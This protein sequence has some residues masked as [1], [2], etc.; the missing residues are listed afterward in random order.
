M[1]VADLLQDVPVWPSTL[2]RLE[3]HSHSFKD[4]EVVVTGAAGSIG[5]A[6]A[7]FLAEAGAKVTGVDHNELE[8]S[9]HVGKDQISWELDDF[10]HFSIPPQTEFIFH[11]AAYKHVDLSARFEKA[12]TENNFNKTVKFVDQARR[13]CPMHTK[14]VVVSTDKAAGNS[15]LG[16]S[17]RDAEQCV[18]AHRGNKYTAIRLVNV[19]R[20][21]GSVLERWDQSLHPW[22]CPAH[23]ER[24]WMT[25]KDAICAILDAA[26]LTRGVYTVQDVP[27]YNMGD[28]AQVYENMTGKRI[29][30]LPELRVGESD[31]EALIGPDEEMVTVLPHIAKIERGNSGKLT[32]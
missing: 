1:I 16:R 12:F 21:R 31:R 2:S 22:V 19:A 5:Y 17:K 30:R 14:L 32:S 20:S 26:F 18:L 11:C 24:Y 9:K 7:T 27:L 15:V 4:K 6:L 29:K 8:V 13:V 25:M 10:V 28:L 3:K 23:V